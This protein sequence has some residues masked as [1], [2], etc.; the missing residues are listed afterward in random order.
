MEWSAAL[1]L[2]RL[3]SDAGKSTLLELCDRSFLESGERYTI[4]DSAGNVRRYAL[5]A[6]RVDELLMAVIDAASN[7][8]D[9]D[10]WG[11][12]QRLGSDPSPAVRAKAAATLKTRTG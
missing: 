5:P 7:L 1:A 9:A 10:V 12:I 3:G 8:D 6:Q 2:A 4:T 11:M